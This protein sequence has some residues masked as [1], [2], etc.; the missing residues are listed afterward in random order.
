MAMERL[1]ELATDDE[2]DWE[3]IVVDTPPTRSALSFL[4]APQRMLDFL[5]GRM[6]RWLLWPYRRAGKAGL[7]GANLGARA[8]AATVGRIAG[9]DLL[10]DTA[11]FLGA[12]EGMYDGFRDRANHVLDLMGQ[13][14]SGSWSSPRPSSA[15][16]RGRPLR[17]PP[18][19]SHAPGRR[20]REPAAPRS[21]RQRC[22]VRDGT[23]AGG[24]AEDRPPRRPDVA[25]R[26]RALERRRPG[27][28]RLRG[29]HDDVPITTVP[30]WRRRATGWG[31]TC[32][33]P[34]VRRRNTDHG[35]G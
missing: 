12:F 28:E 34:P 19:E 21:G 30:S 11:E 32:S 26:L 22:A 3:T 14:E 23:P 2:H 10:R 6:F 4:D 8:M 31:S 7:R 5:G 20:G 33:R 9:A 27:R 13:D 25:D 1:Y 24:D 35:P 18:A 17:G 16:R 15:A 29:S